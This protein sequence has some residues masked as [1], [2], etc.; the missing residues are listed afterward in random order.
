MNTANPQHTNLDKQPKHEAHNAIQAKPHEDSRAAKRKPQEKPEHD[1][2]AR[3]M[4]ER[5]DK[6]P[7]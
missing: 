6:R 4:Q 5:D 7:H 3:H 1:N 2:A